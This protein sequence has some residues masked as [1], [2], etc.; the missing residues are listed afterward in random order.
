MKCI[1]KISIKHKKKCYRFALVPANGNADFVRCRG[2]GQGSKLSKVAFV[3]FPGLKVITVYFRMVNMF[4]LKVW[5][6]V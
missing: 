6:D 2:V 3:T 1:I 5:L 4:T